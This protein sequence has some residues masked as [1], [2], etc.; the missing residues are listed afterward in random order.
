[1]HNEFAYVIKHETDNNVCA[2]HM[3]G[4]EACAQITG[5]TRKTR[6]TCSW[7]FTSVYKSLIAY[8]LALM[9]HERLQLAPKR[10][11]VA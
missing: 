11:I 8:S 6:Q 4:L 5:A 1:M 3:K 7:T 10:Y 9:L 2:L